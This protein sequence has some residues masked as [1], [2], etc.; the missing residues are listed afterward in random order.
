MKIEKLLKIIVWV[1]GILTAVLKYSADNPFD[2][3][4]KEN[5]TD[6]TKQVN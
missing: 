2:D 1:V 4:V 5:E 3:V 6:G